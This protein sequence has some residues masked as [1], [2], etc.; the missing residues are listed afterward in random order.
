MVRGRG[1]HSQAGNAK[2]GALEKSARISRQ[3]T[4]EGE[5]CPTE[6]DTKSLRG[7]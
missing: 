1:S 6:V 4:L 3:I 7:S 5:S 2:Q